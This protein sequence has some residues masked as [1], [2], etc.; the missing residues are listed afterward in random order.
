MKDQL[1]NKYILV[2][3][4]L[5]NRFYRE[6]ILP[7]LHSKISFDEVDRQELEKLILSLV[8]VLKIILIH[9]SINKLFVVLK[10]EYFQEHFRLFLISIK[11]RKIVGSLLASLKFITKRYLIC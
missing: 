5:L 6:Q 10:E 9:N 11:R 7:Y 2:W 3:K 8:I 4:K 1:N